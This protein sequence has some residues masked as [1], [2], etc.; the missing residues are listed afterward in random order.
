MCDW[1]WESF[2]SF[3]KPDLF[4]FSDPGPLHAPINS[5]TL[6]RDAELELVLETVA[7]QD[8]K[9]NATA[10]Q[11]GTV[12]IASESASLICKASAATVTLIGVQPFRHV[13]SVSDNPALREFRETAS[14]SEVSGCVQNDKEPKFI[15]DWLANVEGRFLWPDSTRETVETNT[16]RKIGRGE[17]PVILTSSLESGSS[18]SDCVRLIVD[19]NELYLCFIKDKNEKGV[20]RPGYILY[21]GTPSEAFREKVRVSLSFSLGIYLVHLGHSVF[22]Q[23][24]RLISFKAISGYAL[25]GRAF[26]LP[27]MLPS[28]L[29]VR[30][31]WEID[32]A[33]LSKMVNAICAHYDQLN[34]LSLNWAYWHA[35]CATPHIAPVHYGAAVEA[36]QRAYVKANSQTY[37]TTL[38]CREHW[39]IL[40][41]AANAAVAAMPISEITK[42]ILLNKISGLNSK[43]QSVLVEEVLLNLNLSLSEIEKAAWRHRNEAGHGKSVKSEEATKVI[44][45]TKLLRL[46]FIRMLLAI[47]GA[48]EYY[49]DYYTLGRPTR[50]VSDPIPS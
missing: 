36:L 41:E 10:C 19:G 23:D 47:T 24:W 46:R 39:N 17:D 48:S 40:N 27:P 33:I 18:G 32:S 20:K 25:G 5:F 42:N 11:A 35:V 12:R 45:E 49:Y 30:Y 13:R 34:F 15:I 38:V 21:V 4:K 6:K 1:K 22:C 29:G 14:I 8:A 37:Q 9:S 43:P 2:D 28:P 31:E 50:R 16:T 3:I 7:G 44:R 26:E